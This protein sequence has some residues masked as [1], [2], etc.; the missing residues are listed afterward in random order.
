MNIPHP[1]A[2]SIPHRQDRS[3]ARDCEG[4][5]PYAIMT[6]GKAIV[7]EKMIAA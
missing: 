2:T 6:D 5:N 1:M 7:R 4:S 3:I